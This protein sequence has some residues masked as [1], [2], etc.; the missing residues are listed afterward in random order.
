[1]SSAPISLVLLTEPDVSSLVGDPDRDLVD[2]QVNCRTCEGSCCRLTVM[3]GPKDKAIPHAM[4]ATAENGQRMMARAA[5]GF[6]VAL[7]SD[8]M[9]SIYERR[10]VDCRQFTMGGPYCQAV[11]QDRARRV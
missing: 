5:N 2:P 11:R 7:N 3:L 6:C 1:V 9:C 4:T 10:P 8:H